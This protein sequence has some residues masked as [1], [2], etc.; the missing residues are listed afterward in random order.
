MGKSLIIKGADFSAVAIDTIISV[1]SL[2]T[3]LIGKAWQV[4][5]TVGDNTPPKGTPHLVG[6]NNARFSTTDFVD[7]SSVTS[8][9]SQIKITPKTGYKFAAYFGN[10]VAG[11]TNIVDWRYFTEETTFNVD[12][13]VTQMVIMIA[14]TDGTDFTN[15]TW[16]DCLEESVS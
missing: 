7:I 9:A 12:S 1:L 15:E 3:W 10:G 16:G 13:S 8:R 11:Q 5:G 6:D 14:K 2:G 4:T